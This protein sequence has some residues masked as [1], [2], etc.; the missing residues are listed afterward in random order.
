MF[1]NLIWSWIFQNIQIDPKCCHLDSFWSHIIEYSHIY[2]VSSL[3]L[4]SLKIC[5]TY[6]QVFGVVVGELHLRWEDPGSIPRVDIVARAQPF[7]LCSPNG[8]SLRLDRYTDRRRIPM[9]P[10]LNRKKISLDDILYWC[11]LWK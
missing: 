4:M 8:I 9:S 5:F 1:L 7:R 2:L 6:Q 3:N 10:W 11:V